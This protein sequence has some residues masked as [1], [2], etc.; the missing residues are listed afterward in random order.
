[1]SGTL[2]RKIVLE[3]KTLHFTGIFRPHFYN[4]PLLDERLPD[5]MQFTKRHLPY[6]RIHLF[7][8]GDFLT[9]QSIKTL[10]AAGV[11]EFH[12]TGHE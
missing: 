12:V 10:I 6:C 11:D 4:E 8:N 2:F 7:S 5:L 1:M 3:L 9:D